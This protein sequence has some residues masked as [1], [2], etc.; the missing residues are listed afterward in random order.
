MDNPSGRN[1]AIQNEIA[2]N[3][4]DK[5]SHLKDVYVQKTKIQ[6]QNAAV[7]IFLFI[8]SN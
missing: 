6:S 3:K 7:I 5:I 2:P 4:M 1:D 8:S